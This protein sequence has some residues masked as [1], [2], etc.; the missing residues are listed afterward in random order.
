VFGH[1]DSRPA[2]AAGLG[3]RAEDLT[4][5]AELG[6]RIATEYAVSSPA[7]LSA[8]LTRLLQRRVPVSRIEHEG[9]ADDAFHLRFADGTVLSVRG[10]H[11]GDI[12]WAAANALLHRVELASY[13]CRATG[14]TLELVG[15]RRHVRLR[16]VGVER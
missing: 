7:V 8:N 5:L 13:E 11:P 10:E 12:G 1:R 15:G 9:G 3:L 2:G 4:E 6:Q 14:V 16:A